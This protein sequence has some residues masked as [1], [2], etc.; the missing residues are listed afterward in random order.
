[1]KRLKN[2]PKKTRGIA[3]S[4][5]CLLA[6]T[7]LGLAT[8]TGKIAAEP[9]AVTEV[10][11]GLLMLVR[12]WDSKTGELIGW[13]PIHRV[14][15]TLRHL[16]EDTPSFDLNEAVNV[17]FP[18]RPSAPVK[19][20]GVHVVSETA[21]FQGRQWVPLERNPNLVHI[22]GFMFYVKTIDFGESQ[23]RRPTVVDPVSQMLRK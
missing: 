5:C 2:I 1:M 23:W 11:N 15:I 6:L 8:F 4:A 14:A 18:Y 20:G 13:M 3:M 17:D 19:Y 16:G 9:A 22:R 10:P 12:A 7:T 21:T